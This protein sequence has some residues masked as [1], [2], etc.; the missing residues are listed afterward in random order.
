MQ[1]E[2]FGCFVGLKAIVGVFDGCV[3]G[4]G[5]WWVVLQQKKGECKWG[6]ERV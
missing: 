3:C 5:G 4:G 6:G 1:N 2:F